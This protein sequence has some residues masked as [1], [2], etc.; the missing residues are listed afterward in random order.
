MTPEAAAANHLLRSG[1]CA[2]LRALAFGLT[3]PLRQ[4]L[5]QGAGPIPSATLLHTAVLAGALFATGVRVDQ[6]DRQSHDHPH[7]PDLHHRN[8]HEQP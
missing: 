3:T 4:R 5:R 8:G 2:R 1:A 6:H 7:A